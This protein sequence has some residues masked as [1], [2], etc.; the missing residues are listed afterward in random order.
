MKNLNRRQFIKSSALAAGAA[1]LPARIWSQAPGANGDVRIAV[2]GFNSRGQ[3]HIDAYL[4]IPGVRIVALCD[5]DQEVLDREA[6]KFQ[7]RN[8]PLETYRDIRKLLDN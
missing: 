8:Q 1:A 3:E 7:N 2:I 5:V 6:R 4:K